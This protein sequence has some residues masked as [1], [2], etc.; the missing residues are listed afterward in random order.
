MYYTVLHVWFFLVYCTATSFFLLVLVVPFSHLFNP[1]EFEEEPS[2][3][4][5]L[6]SFLPARL[7]SPAKKRPPD[8]HVR[9]RKTQPKNFVKLLPILSCHQASLILHLPHFNVAEDD[10]SSVHDANFWS[11]MLLLGCN[12]INYSFEREGGREGE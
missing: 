6:P 5:F 7:I 2:D 8:A 11:G 12:L 1:W 3:V 10:L 9:R 4:T